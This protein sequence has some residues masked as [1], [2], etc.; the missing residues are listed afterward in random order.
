MP[1]LERAPERQRCRPAL[2]MTWA[3]MSA[4]QRCTA[5]GGHRGQVSSPSLK[6]CN[7]DQRCSGSLPQGPRGSSTLRSKTWPPAPQPWDSAMEFRGSSS[8]SLYSAQYHQA[9]SFW[10]AGAFARGAVEPRR[11]RKAACDSY[12]CHF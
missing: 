7:A 4:R 9:L 8:S 3:S 5:T 1:D 12:I 2:S 6:L 10:V 11:L